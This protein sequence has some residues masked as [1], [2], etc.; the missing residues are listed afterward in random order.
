MSDIIDD[1]IE[2]LVRARE[3]E[4]SRDAC[5][6]LVADVYAAPWS[7][8]APKV[9]IDAVRERAFKVAS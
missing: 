1:V 3:A 5:A 8:P 7:P 4:F 6:A 2:V 9:Q